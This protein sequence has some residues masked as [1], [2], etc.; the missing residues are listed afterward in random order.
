MHVT[1]P[2]LFLLIVLS[3]HLIQSQAQDRSAV[4][5]GKIP[6]AEFKKLLIALIVVFLLLCLNSASRANSISNAVSWHYSWQ[7]V[8]QRYARHFCYTLLFPL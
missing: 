2:K 6:A 1:V 7:N 8:L 3:S 5:F 4:K